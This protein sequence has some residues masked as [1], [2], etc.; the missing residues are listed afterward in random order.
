MPPGVAGTI[1]EQ[2]RNAAVIRLTILFFLLFIQYLP[3][4][5][6][7]LYHLICAVNAGIE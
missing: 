5:F 1:T 2:S 4:L 7:V 3:V 6:C